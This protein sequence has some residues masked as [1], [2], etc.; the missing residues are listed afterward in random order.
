MDTQFIGSALLSYGLVGV[1][2]L[3]FVEKFLPMVP[4]SAFLLLVGMNAT[5]L[6]GHLTGAVLA[7]TLGSTLGAIA[8]YL[9]GR[10]A[11][12]PPLRRFAERFFW[13][14]PDVR[15][16]RAATF[17]RDH[18]F[19]TTVI[20]QLVP[21]VRVYVAFPAGVARIAFRSFLMATVLGVF[22]W[23]TLFLLLGHLLQTPTG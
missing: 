14:M 6:P 10:T 11:G 1:A 13:S 22:V 15:A 9:I 7:S 3:A 17:Y 18:H 16:R 8:W 19:L 23:N 12:P 20:S 4:S 21:T 2:L 5:L